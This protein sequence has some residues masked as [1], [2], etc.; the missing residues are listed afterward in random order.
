MKTPKHLETIANVAVL[1]GLGVFLFG[2]DGVLLEKWDEWRRSER[3]RQEVAREW[4]ALVGEGPRLARGTPDASRYAA[5][6]P[7]SIRRVW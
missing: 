1:V 2:P 3:V 6:P 7:S 4:D 5:R